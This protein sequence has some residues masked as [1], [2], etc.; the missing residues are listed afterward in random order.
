MGPSV[1]TLHRK[2]S[3]LAIKA[4]LVDEQTF[5]RKLQKVKN[6]MKRES[7]QPSMKVREIEDIQEQ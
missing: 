4:K 7:S 1:E 3:E 5:M 2:V 6:S